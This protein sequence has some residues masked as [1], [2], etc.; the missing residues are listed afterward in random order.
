MLTS[1]IARP[2]L[3]GG[4]VAA[5][6]VAGCSHAPPSAPPPA[7]NT[8]APRAAAPAP[9]PAAPTHKAKFS[10]DTMMGVL[11]DDPAT[12]AVL[13]RHVPQV[14]ASNQ[15]VMAR[16]LTLKQLAGFAQAGISPKTLSAIEAD[17]SKLN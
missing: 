14:V 2:I 7:A 6:A 13:Q 10:G 8:P 3:T 1:P 9:A 16:G 12:R 11:L 4:F 15:I 5:L 17:L